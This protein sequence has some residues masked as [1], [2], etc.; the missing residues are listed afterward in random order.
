MALETPVW[1]EAVAGDPVITYSARQMRTWV[2]AVFAFE[3]IIRAG[4]L[5]V[6]QRAAGANMSVDV[7]AGMV[8]ITGD[9]VVFQGKVVARNTASFN[10]PITTAPT[11]GT[12][13]DLIVAQLYDKQAAGG[14]Q[15]AWNIIALPGTV[16]VPPSAVLLA[17]ISV[18]ANVASI[19]NSVITDKRAGAVGVGGRP[20]YSVQAAEPAYAAAGTTNFTSA[21]WPALT[22]TVP[23]SGQ[24]FVSITGNLQN[25]TTGT[26]TVFMLWGVTAGTITILA[27]QALSAAGGRTYGTKRV[28]CTGV[29]GASVTL[30]PQWSMS[31]YTA[32]NG[33][34]TDGLLAVEPVN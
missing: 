28:L 12:R 17:Q 8:V 20:V 16:I 13:T 10:V 7:A 33:F 29:P 24:F 25:I 6:T 19:T 5:K 4:D 34:I 23:A 15:Y 11:T 26:S 1:L 9:D 3:G 27:N 31:S 18:G 2:D 22:F 21:Q 30:T 32:G 14:T